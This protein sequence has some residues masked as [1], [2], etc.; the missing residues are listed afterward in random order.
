MTSPTGG[1]G[2]NDVTAVGRLIFDASAVRSGVASAHASLDTMYNVIRNNWWG[3]R[4]I[5]DAFQ[6]V[7]AAATGALGIAAGAAINFQS[8]MAA[9]ARTTADAHNSADVTSKSVQDL[10]KQLQAISEIRPVGLDTLTQIAESA[11]ALGIKR[12]DVAA[13]TKTIVDLISTTNLTTDSATQLA[14]VANIFGLSGQQFQQLGSAIYQVGVNTAATEQDIVD[15]TVRLAPAAKQ[16][17]LTTAQTTGLAAATLSL[18]VQSEAAGTALSRF[19]QQLE[20]AASGVD[21]AQLTAYAGVIGT[22]T[23][24]FQQLVQQDPS[25]AMIRVVDAL[26]KIS[27]EGG[28]TTAAL[29]AMGI[30]EQREVRTINALVEGSKS[31]AQSYLSLKGA[32]QQATSAFN[33]GNKATDAANQ[34]N[35]TMGAQLTEL[36]NIVHN[37]AISF[38]NDLA[39]SMGFVLARGRDL[40][41]M[42]EKIPGPIKQVLVYTTAGV[43]AFATLGGV[44]LLLL[45][46]LSLAANAYRAM[47]ASMAIALNAQRAKIAAN[48]A[49]TQS[50]LALAFATGRNYAALQAEQQAQARQAAQIQVTL[51]LRRAEL[52]LLQ[53]R[54]RLIDLQAQSQAIMNGESEASL[55]TTLKQIQVQ[56]AEIASIEQTIIALEGESA[57]L[58]ETTASMGFFATA[59]TL[60]GRAIGALGG[61]I[62][63]ALV[64]LTAITSAL[65]F[66]GHS[67]Q[68]AA[69][70]AEQDAQAVENLKNQLDATTNSLTK[71]GQAAIAQKLATDKLGDKSIVDNLREL[72]LNATLF[73][74]AISQGVDSSSYKEAA[75][76]INDLKIQIIDSSGL[77]GK[78]KQYADAAGLSQKD[79]NDAIL[80][81]TDKWND[82]TLAINAAEGP[83]ASSK[84]EYL[85]RAQQDLGDKI[86]HIN[87]LYNILKDRAGQTTEAQKEQVDAMRILLPD[88]AKAAGVS[89]ET[90]SNAFADW[91]VKGG[92]FTKILAGANVSAKQIDAIMKVLTGDSANYTSVTQRASNSTAK[93]SG[94]MSSVATEL[95]KTHGAINQNIRDWIALEFAQQGVITIAHR[96]GISTQDLVGATTKANGAQARHIQTILAHAVAA[97]ADAGQV[98]KLNNVIAQLA[99]EFNAAQKV[100][101]NTILAQDDLGHSLQNVGQAAQDAAQNTRTYQQVL[102]DASQAAAQLPQD[103]LSVEQATLSLQQ[104]EDQLAQAR[105]AHARLPHDLGEAELE[106]QLA[107]EK[108]KDAVQAVRQAEKD[109]ANWRA[110]ARAQIQDDTEAQKSAQLDY[111]DSVTKVHDAEKALRDLREHGEEDHLQRLTDLTNKLRD[112]QNSLSNAQLKASDAQYQLNY[113]QAEGASAR[114]IAN[115]Q[116]QLRDAHAGVADAVTAVGTAQDNLETERQYNLAKAIKAAE[117][118]V[119]KAVLAERDAL[120]KL[121]DATQKLNTDRRDLR[122][123]TDYRRAEEAL[124]QTELD[125]AQAQD[126]VYNSRQKLKGVQDLINDDT[127]LASANQNVKSA[128]LALADAQTTLHDDLRTANGEIVTSYQHLQ[129]FR[130]K[131]Q[132]IAN[133]ISGKVGREI[134]G[135]TSKLR[136]GDIRAHVTA[137]MSG[138]DTVIHKAHKMSQALAPLTRPNTGKEFIV[139]DGVV[140]GTRMASRTGANAVAAG[141]IIQGATSFTYGDGSQGIAGEGATAEAIIPLYDLWQNLAPLANIAAQNAETNR[142]LAQVISMQRHAPGAGPVEQNTYNHYD[143]KV[144]A[145]TDADA[146]LIGRDIVWNIRAVS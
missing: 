37:V 140:I 23:A 96:L 80:G 99:G 119:T 4:A 10:G 117:E 137:S 93:L 136:V 85:T 128:A 114:D 47:S 41:T 113:L 98:N 112:A 115:A 59:A 24:K 101:R 53:A 146:A 104:A 81:S 21:P 30:T 105:A 55:V 63:V 103:Q 84:I 126:Q 20:R 107:R 141:G 8:G 3:L 90:L 125:L 144:E 87:D 54:I 64:A 6:S 68:E 29:D 58:A 86:S 110:N 89:L 70:A 88:A 50:T 39:P 12:E 69:A 1:S 34:Q 94:N 25:E 74:Q 18:G 5:G 134:G 28:N 121:H 109:L 97:G 19:F 75:K 72:G 91:Q 143:V 133:D 22:T 45:P 79:F 2:S 145:H 46:R 57:A 116:N 15:L 56:E 123:G 108:E 62:G 26:A 111:R 61:P 40:A 100:A 122:N 11:G 138:D 31:G 76:S 142:L 9:V 135:L 14:K 44:L 124:Q 129:T 7:G 120:G 60:A 66:W 78:Y 27:K 51:Q 71:A 35:K 16:F 73:A 49:E 83:G 13:F 67:N 36:K 52:A 92:D 82:L 131:L 32:F 132:G 102:D 118:D 38:G 106:L 17:G 77:Y 127:N 33:D 42:F 43:G 130:D 95:S 48:G 65:M 139:L